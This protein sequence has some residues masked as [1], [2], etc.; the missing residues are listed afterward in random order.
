MDHEDI[1]RL[2]WANVEN[3]Q[4]HTYRSKLVRGEKKKWF[5]IPINREVAAILKEIRQE[6][7][8]QHQE[9]NIFERK[10]IFKAF[11]AAVKRAGLY[12]PDPHQ[13]MTF[14]TL[15]HTFASHLAIQGRHRKE[16]AELMGH[17]DLKL[18]MR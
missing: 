7:G 18:T 2:T 4:I 1:E 14:K 17:R 3:E 6:R 11:N 5:T 13:N 15:R 8:I 10:I 12:S 9:K 16:I